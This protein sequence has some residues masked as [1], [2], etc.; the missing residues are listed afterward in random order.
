MPP[1]RSTQTSTAAAATTTANTP[2]PAPP[3]SPRQQQQAP[4][5]PGGPPGGGG[6]GGG[7]GPPGGNPPAAP[8]AAAYYSM[9][10]KAIGNFLDYTN[11][12]HVHMFNQACQGL[13]SD[14]AERFDGNPE[15]I[16][17]FVG[18]IRDWVL[19]FSIVVTIMPV[20]VAQLALANP[21]T[22]DFL[23][24]FGEVS[25]DF[26]RA[27]VTTYLGT[28]TLKAQQDVMLLHMVL[29]SLAPGHYRTVTTDR[30]YYTINGIE[31]GLLLLLKVLIESKVKTS[32]DPDILRKRISSAKK[33]LNVKHGGNVRE[34]TTE[35]EEIMNQLHQQGE[36]CTDILTHLW[37]A[38]KSHTDPKLVHY[39]SFQQDQVRDG[40]LSDYTW[41]TLLTNAK[42]KYDSILADNAADDNFEDPIAALE[43]E[44]QNQNKI[45]KKIMRQN[46]DN[47]N[48]N[49]GSDGGGKK[50]G[51]GKGKK[52]Q[53]KPFPKELKK[54]KA[55]ADPSKPLV[56]DEVEYWW[57]EKHNKW[58]KHPTYKC[59]AG[60][61][62]GD[63]DNGGSRGG[64]A[65]RALAALTK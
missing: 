61:T 7:G 54:K 50:P 64:R 57:C 49:P 62:D 63:K 14:P 30:S 36:T 9:P 26:L 4:P 27:Y 29:N 60:K 41:K 22:M 15:E 24:H 42:S 43:A 55:P 44:I 31:C 52:K 12:Q 47:G 65:V 16:Q 19:L 11:K 23:L 8:N 51:K 58:G 20:N 45:L 18:K 40:H 53:W 35:V 21:Q 37:T 33:L 56:I 25:Y 13:F 28:P 32:A 39:I 34:F 17:K 3:A 2:A 59:E 1:K 48:G 6:G 10:S 5:P 38:L 46:N